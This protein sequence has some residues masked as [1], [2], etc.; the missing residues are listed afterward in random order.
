MNFLAILLEKVLGG[1][2]SKI[3]SAIYA[4]AVKI[5]KSI[6][7]GNVKKREVDKYV[8]EINRLSAIAKEEATQFGRVTDATELAMSRILQRRNLGLPFDDGL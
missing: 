4:W 5:G 6:Y 8:E 7:R 1:W 3:G 2:L